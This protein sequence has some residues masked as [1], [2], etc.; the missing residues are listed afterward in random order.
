MVIFGN[1]KMLRLNKIII[2]NFQK[3]SDLQIDFCNDVNV[4]LGATEVGKTCIKHAIEFLCQHDTF[5]GQRK[6]APRGSSQIYTKSTSVTGEFSSG[7]IV[8]R[9]ISNSINR[10]ILT[11]DGK[12]DVF[13]SVGKT[14]PDE[15][16]EAIG[17]YP[18]EIGDHEIYL[19]SYTQVGKPFL[20]DLTPS[21]RAKIFNKLTGND[22]LDKLFGQ[23]NKDIL[24]IKRDIREETEQFEERTTLLKSKK[25]EFEKAEAIHIKLKKRVKNIKSLYEKYSKLLELKELEESNK[26]NSKETK[27]KL[28]NLKFPQDTDIK[29]L[30]ANIDRF[31]ELQNV[32]KAYEKAQ[33]LLEKVKG[34][35]KA[36]R[37]PELN[38]ACLG[39]KIERY[40]KI[41]SIYEKFSH[42]RELFSKNRQ[43]T[44]IVEKDFIK[45]I[46]QYK[47]L[48]KKAEILCPNCKHDITEYCFK[49][50]KL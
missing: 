19:N 36:F 31:E 16:K 24:R 27:V 18:I 3:H 49:E 30:K 43:N 7:V 22:I 41:Q 14:A 26:I 6:L 32:K 12:E 37:L 15:I 42:N 5:V 45:A 23:F 4:I 2:K 9:V 17:I 13:N 48:L 21:D 35:L 44:K 25:K 40:G 50:I 8:E 11:K 47:A 38:M 33:T 29:Q 34:Q 46:N 39:A 28:N 20:F 10:Y 1:I